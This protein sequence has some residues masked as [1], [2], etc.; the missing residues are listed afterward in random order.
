DRPAGLQRNCGPLLRL[1]R[2]FRY[3]RTGRH[4]FHPGDDPAGDGVALVPARSVPRHLQP[5]HRTALTSAAC[6]KAGNTPPGLFATVPSRQTTALIVGVDRIWFRGGPCG[7]PA[8]VSAC[9]P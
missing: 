1:L 2:P 4:S 3:F 6:K 5:P 7:S 8:S 9:S